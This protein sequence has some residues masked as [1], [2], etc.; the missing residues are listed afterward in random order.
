M[1]RLARLSAALLL[2]VAS[3]V[4]LGSAPAYA[5]RCAFADVSRQADRADAVFVGSFA[6]PDRTVEGGRITFDLAVD[7]VYRGEVASRVTVVAPYSSATC[8]LD[9]IPAGEPVL[10][11]VRGAPPGVVR[12]D[13][14]SGTTTLTPKLARQLE[15]AVGPPGSPVADGPTPG[16]AGS[17]D[18]TSG[19]QTE[20][21]SGLF[22]GG[23]PWWAWTA[24]LLAV[25]AGAALAL[26]RT[27]RSEGPAGP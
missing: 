20:D 5:C 1:A 3:V 22:Q 26:R 15:R 9:G 2:A 17:S 7:D 21:T 12:S 13:L 14:C 16:S 23:P 25:G 19:D 8:G 11:F 27:F 24:G 10:W 18:Q 4:L 6:R